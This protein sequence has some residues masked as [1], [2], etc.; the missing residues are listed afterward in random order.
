[1]TRDEARAW[2]TRYGETPP[3]LRWV[4]K[5][6]HR[7]CSTDLGGECLDEIINVACLVW[8]GDEVK[9]QAGGTR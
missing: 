7:E 2:L 1:M 5:H 4:C 8:E 9:T 3:A 6:G